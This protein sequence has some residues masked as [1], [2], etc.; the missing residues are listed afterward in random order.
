[1]YP[2]ITTPDLRRRP[3][4]RPA[5]EG[6]PL[7]LAEGNAA[8]RLPVQDLGRARAF[9][10]DKLGLTPADERPGGLLYQS[11]GCGFE[12]FQSA[13]Q[14]PG[15]FTQMG[16]T[17]PDL[18]AEV[19]ELRSR[20]VVTVPLIVTMQFIN[21]GLLLW[22]YAA[23]VIPATWCVWVISTRR[24]RG[25]RAFSLGIIRWM[26]QVR[27]IVSVVGGGVAAFAVYT[28]TYLRDP[29]W[30]SS[31]LQPL[32]LY[33]AMFSAFVTTSGSRIL[34]LDPAA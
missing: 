15:T 11:R 1:M 5:E 24:D 23:A 26:L 14:S 10:R 21:G 34:R 28:A 30:G 12:L 9:Y 2:E 6:R 19:A 31:A 8:A 3:G 16:W 7:M 32:T 4:P 29:T 17:V 22:L 13:G 18:D 20:G 25:Q 33:G 27:G